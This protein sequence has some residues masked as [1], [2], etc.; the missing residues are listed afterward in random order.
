VTAYLVVPAATGR[1]PSASPMSARLR[2]PVAPL[3]FLFA[4]HEQL[5]HRKAMERY[6][7]AATGAKTVKW[8]DAGHDLNDPQ[9]LIDRA[10]WL[11]ERFGLRSVN[12]ILRKKLGQD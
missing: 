1:V 3:L 12:E 5:F 4:N 11:K 6:A 7:A 2:R 10:A 9:A 8:Y